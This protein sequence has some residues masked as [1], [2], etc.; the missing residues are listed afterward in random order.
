M[1][2]FFEEAGIVRAEIDRATRTMI[3]T[4]QNLGPHDHIRPA[5]E[6]QLREVKGGARYL[7]LDTSETGG[8]VSQD[9]QAWFGE[10]LFPAFADAGLEAIVTVVPESAIAQLSSKGWMRTAS[11]FGFEMYEAAS[12]EDAARVIDGQVAAA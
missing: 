7:I 9:D 6:A 8:V 10:V 2:T 1:R 4:W 3:V 11:P 5:C 12:V